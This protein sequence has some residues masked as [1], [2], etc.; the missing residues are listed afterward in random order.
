MPHI[1]DR[2][3]TYLVWALVFLFGVSIGGDRDVV[4]KLHGFGLTALVV[5]VF[6]VMG[7]VLGAWAL[8]KWRKRV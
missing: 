2:L 7:S 6:S 8:W 5:A 4:S 1:P 3:M